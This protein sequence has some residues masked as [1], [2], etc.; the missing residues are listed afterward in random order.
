MI[1][2]GKMLPKIRAR[3]RRDLSSTGLS[4]EK[5]LAT[6]VRLLEATHI[7]IGNEE[8]SKQNE[9]FGL[10]TLRGRHVETKG[11]RVS[12]YFRGKSGKKHAISIEDKHLA[13]IVRRLVDL[14]GYELFQYLDDSG[15]RHSIGSADVNA[16]LREISREDFSS[17][18]FRTWNATVLTAMALS[19]VPPYKSKREANRNLKT[20]IEDV[21]RNLGNTVAVCRQCYIHPAVIECYIQKSLPRLAAN[22]KHAVEQA[23]LRLLQRAA[24]ETQPLKQAA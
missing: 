2:F 6:I 23:V 14:P 3:A 16:Y 12:F 4:R 18:D 8:Y 17:K 24:R 15:E 9:S 7:R 21:A 11:S 1:A 5:V 22:S 13:K 10:T 19:R 20:A